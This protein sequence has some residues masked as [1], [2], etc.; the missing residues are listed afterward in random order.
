VPFL[1]IQNQNLV[2]SEKPKLCNRNISQEE[3]VLHR[4]LKQMPPPGGGAICF[5]CIYKSHTEL[6]HPFAPGISPDM[7]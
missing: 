3:A 1:N 2:F 7:Q 5:F 6:L 4:W